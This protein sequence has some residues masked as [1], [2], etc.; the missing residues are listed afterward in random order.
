MR[1]LVA[2]P[3]CRRQFDASARAIGSRFRCHCGTVVTVRRPQGH[4]AAVVRCSSCGAP[5]QHGSAAC[6]HCGSDFT[7]HEQD[8][9]TICPG[10][11]ARISNRAKF[12]HH[13]GLPLMPESLPGEKTDLVCP[14][15]GKMSRLGS[16]RIGDVSIKECDRCAGMWI[17]AGVLEQ[18]VRKATTDLTI[19]DFHV[20]ASARP[21]IS[22]YTTKQRGPMYRCCPVCGK[23]MNRR[24]FARRSGVIIDA[25][26]KHGVWFDFDELPRILGW[27]RVG[28]KARAE[29]EAAVEAQR[30]ARLNAVDLRAKWRQRNDP[31]YP[32]HDEIRHDVD[33]LA[34]LARVFLK[35]FR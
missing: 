7:L 32:L 31:S 22:A 5:R 15:C 29:R 9:D 16:R 35:M 8:L 25:C 27:V 1:L 6:T 3:Q 20:S 19:E 30:Q 11:F 24:N 17:D 23:M 28:G 14:V 34:V 21:E 33:I 18:L 10:C 4:D 26:N 13:C 12:C 2:C